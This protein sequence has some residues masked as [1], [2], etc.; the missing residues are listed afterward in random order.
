MD[1]IFTGFLRT[2]VP[3]LVGGFVAWLAT[4]GILVEPSVENSL[5]SAIILFLGSIL[6]GLYYLTVRWLA[7]KFPWLEKLIGS[8]KTPEYKE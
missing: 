1:S 6:T 8:S 3:A 5:A 7:T 4:V 2:I